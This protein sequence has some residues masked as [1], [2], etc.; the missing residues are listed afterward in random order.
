MVSDKYQISLINSDWAFS[1]EMNSCM[2]SI[3]ILS[4]CL[5]MSVLH[6]NNNVLTHFFW[7]SGTVFLHF[8][9]FFKYPWIET[10]SKTEVQ[11]FESFLIEVTTLHFLRLSSQE[12]IQHLNTNT[13][14]TTYDSTLRWQM[15]Y[16]RSMLYFKYSNKCLKAWFFYRQQ[17]IFYSYAILQIKSKISLYLVIFSLYFE[18]VKTFH[19]AMFKEHLYWF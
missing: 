5:I 17:F 8:E 2:F 11:C 1:P 10:C 7:V 19:T 18:Y 6:C 9:I 15:A 16:S 13:Y 12:L 4:N 14:K 3:L